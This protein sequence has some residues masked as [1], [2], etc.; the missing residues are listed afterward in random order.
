MKIYEVDSTGTDLVLLFRNT[1]A[2]YNHAGLPAKF[3]WDQLNADMK[4][5]DTPQI[6]YNSFNAIYNQDPDMWKTVVRS[7]SGEGIELNT[8]AKAAKKA[9][10]TTPDKRKANIAKMAKNAAKKRQG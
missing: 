1:I 7:Y 10:P 8:E 9:A 6:D 4:G 5:S 2:K 3:T